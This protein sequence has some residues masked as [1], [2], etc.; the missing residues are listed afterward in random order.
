MSTS[1]RNEGNVGYI[2]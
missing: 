2:R 1:T